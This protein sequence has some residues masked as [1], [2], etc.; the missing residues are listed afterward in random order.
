MW[1]DQFDLVSGP[2]RQRTIAWLSL[3]SHDNDSS[4]FWIYLMAALKYGG[5]PAEQQPDNPFDQLITFIQSGQQ[6]SSAFI[7]SLINKIVETGREYI[8]V[9]EDYHVIQSLEIQDSL[10]YLLEHQPPN[11]RLVIAT[12][13]DP[14]LPLPRLRGRGELSEL[15]AADFRFSN[16][17][18]VDFF[19]ENVGYELSLQDAVA[20]DRNI[21]GWPAGLHMAALAFKADNAASPAEEQDLLRLPQFMEDISGK[22]GFII[23][24][25]AEEVFLN[26]PD[27][28][29][30]F[31]LKTS[32]LERMNSPLC[33]SLLEPDWEY[34]QN[35]SEIMVYLEQ[36]NLFIIPLDNERNWYR[37]H[38]LFADLLKARLN[39]LK[40]G[41]VPELHRRASQWYE[42]KNMIGEAVLHAQK[43]SDLDRAAML[44]E[45]YHDT[46]IDKGD[47]STISSW[48]DSLSGDVLRYRPML[49]VYMAWALAF[50]GKTQRIKEL[51]QY[52]SAALA[53]WEAF[54]TGEGI[55]LPFE[56]TKTQTLKIKAYALLPQGYAAII[57]GQPGNILERAEKALEAL[58]SSRSK[59]A[60]YLNWLAGF[61]CRS[62][63]NLDRAVSYQSEAVAIGRTMETAI[64]VL[65]F[66]NELG[67]IFRLQGKLNSARELFRDTLGWVQGKGVSG[68]GFVSRVE[69]YLSS[70]LLEQNNLEEAFF[71][72]RKALEVLQGWPNH[73]YMATAYV[74]YGNILLATGDVKN[75]EENILRAEL[76]R[77][78]A[79]VDL[80]VAVPVMAGLM[81]LWLTK[82]D[83]QAA[84]SLAHEI[85]VELL[86]DY[87]SGNELNEFREKK[88]IILARFHL[89]R[90]RLARE[91]K[92]FNKTTR[93]LLALEQPARKTGRVHSLI[94]IA[95]LKAIAQYLQAGLEPQSAS[96]LH[97][98]ALQCLEEALAEGVAEGY[99]RIFINEGQIMAELLTKMLNDKQ[100]AKADPYPGASEAYMQKLLKSFPPEFVT[101]KSSSINGMIERLTE[102][103]LEILHMLGKGFSNKEMA[104]RLYLSEGTVKTHV[105]NVLGKLG[106]QS[107]TQAVAR[108]RELKLL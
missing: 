107:R 20:I 45:N 108:G 103:E 83:W 85:E 3:E 34:E 66:Q 16:A 6:P 5:N 54:Q 75:A 14:P 52:A 15:R 89:A 100:A 4:R 30:E 18:I 10:T 88:M 43:A 101:V 99:Q 51:L 67:D 105:H 29:R 87:L 94:E 102:R 49:C 78:S 41:L 44:M 97:E 92:L 26:Q 95:V 53:Q 79:P 2:D 19:K 106:A 42:Q 31:L 93:L 64:E 47:L 11:L 55:K 12:R 61:A 58:E 22:Q 13:I 68:H 71:H 21:E 104:E 40:P 82:P 73:N 76:E 48:V 23:D 84:E 8:L 65:L 50:A 1:F 90:A 39:H 70:V 36:A 74:N 56:L 59:E 35:S 32:I 17:E 60:S 63:G 33:T 91:L 57:A 25:L 86:S 77:K 24:Y 81:N 27:Y 28:V 38:H 37:Y 7:D 72:A 80:R 96:L 62:L 69:A 9:M 98:G 46:L